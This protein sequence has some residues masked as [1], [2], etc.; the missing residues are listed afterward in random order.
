MR[1]VA[2]IEVSLP[3]DPLGLLYERG[4][5]THGRHWGAARNRAQ[6]CTGKQA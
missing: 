5:R 3:I 6:T 4:R 1:R 2:A